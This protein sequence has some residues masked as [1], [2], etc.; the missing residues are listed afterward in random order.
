MDFTL[1]LVYQFK[2]R[3]FETK[4]CGRAFPVF[5]LNVLFIGMCIEALAEALTTP[6]FNIYP[7]QK[8]KNKKQKSKKKKKK[9]IL[10]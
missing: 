6:R 4:H 2:D 8:T 5:C 1:L 7:E 9:N 10:K 3:M